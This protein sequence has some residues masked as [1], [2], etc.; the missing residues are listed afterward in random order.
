M[1]KQLSKVALGASAMALVAAG[2]LVGA[3]S[4]ANATSCVG[5]DVSTAAGSNTCS[6]DGVTFTFTGLSFSPNAAG[7]ALT[8]AGV[9][10]INNDL[11]LQFQINGLPPLD[12]LLDYSA[13]GTGLL[14]IDAS[15]GSAG[16]DGAI[17]ER[18]RHTELLEK[19]G[20]YYNLYM[21]QFRRDPQ[22]VEALQNGND[23]HKP[24]M[25]LDPSLS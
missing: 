22:F 11:T 20:F 21:S 25:K 18:G 19:K 16:N 23:G 4:A 3:T 9:S 12:V 7:D 6:A 17:I 5:F 24:L 13:T 1:L 8:I 15:Y 2:S 14:G 10:D